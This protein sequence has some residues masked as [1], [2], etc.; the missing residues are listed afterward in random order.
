MPPKDDKA[1]SRDS[2]VS[3]QKAAKLREQASSC[4]LLRSNPIRGEELD[5]YEPRTL[6][7]DFKGRDGCDISNRLKSFG[8]KQYL[9]VLPFDLNCAS[10][11]LGGKFGQ[12]SHLDTLN[13]CITIEFPELNGRLKVLGTLMFAETQYFGLDLPLMKQNGSGDVQLAGIYEHVI[14]FSEFYWIGSAEENPDERPLDMPSALKSQFREQSDN[15]GQYRRH[16]KPDILETSEFVQETPAEIASPLRA[17]TNSSTGSLKRSPGPKRRKV[18]VIDDD[19]SD[20]DSYSSEIASSSEN[21]FS[22]ID[23]DSS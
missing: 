9:L 22:Q 1:F 2:P 15:D 3:K 11:K 6:S 13:P 16:I 4:S 5:S 20:E 12:L 19:S 14:V 7:L 17:R 21:S 8:A 10:A 18:V 23:T